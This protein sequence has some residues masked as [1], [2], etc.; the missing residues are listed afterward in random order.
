MGK[1]TKFRIFQYFIELTFFLPF[2][3]CITKNL[4]KHETEKDTNGSLR[5]VLLWIEMAISQIHII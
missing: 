4:T 5:C 1:R 2:L 3:E